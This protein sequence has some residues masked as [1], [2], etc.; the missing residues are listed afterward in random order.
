MA[1]ARNARGCCAALASSPRLPV[2]ANQISVYVCDIKCDDTQ[3]YA[4][5]KERDML[6]RGNEKLASMNDLIKEKDA[7]IKQVAPEL[8]LE[9]FTNRRL[10][11]GPV[12]CIHYN[13]CS[14]T[15]YI[16]VFPAWDEM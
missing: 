13:P 1:N 4:L 7:I 12:C 9:L 2:L 10:G 15:A 16:I 8:I 6:R 5:S 14:G 3:V 11:C